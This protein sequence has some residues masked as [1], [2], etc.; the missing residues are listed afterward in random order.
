MSERIKKLLE[1]KKAEEPSLERRAFQLTELRIENR[2][3]GKMPKII[4]HAA[5]FNKLSEVLSWGYREKIEPGAFKKTI[6][7]ADIRSL[8]NH[9]P[10][11]VL[12]RNKSGTLK[13]SEDDTG[14]L[15]ETDPPD[16]TWARDLVTTITRKDVDQ[17][18]FAF[19]PII[20]KWDETNPEEP[21]RSLIEVKLFDISPVTFP[22]YPDTDVGVR[23]ILEKAKID[24]TL[25]SRAVGKNTY[26][27]PLSPEEIAIVRSTIEVLQGIPGPAQADHPEEPA[28]KVSRFRLQNLKRWLELVEKSL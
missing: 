14:L 20:Q 26:G 2:E 12:G 21:V 17:M 3:E 15:T 25:L 22:A 13:L 27:M 18:S 24:F 4:G 1:Q 28:E 8:F 7:E 19:L 10:N 5:V 9:D 16:T 6:A 11:Y 23:S